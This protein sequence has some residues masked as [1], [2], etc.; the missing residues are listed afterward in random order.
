MIV[1]V[2]LFVVMLF[3]VFL[4]VVMTMGDRVVVVRVRM[5]P[6]S[7]LE[8]VPDAAVVVMADVPV[9]VRVFDRRMGMGSGLAV[10]ISSLRH[11]VSFPGLG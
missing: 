6:G 5:P 3:F 2:R 1:N 7:M 4:A 8:V 11:R 9:V 10:S